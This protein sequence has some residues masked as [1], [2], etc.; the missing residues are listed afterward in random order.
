MIVKIGILQ[1][2]PFSMTKCQL[3]KHIDKK[4]KKK[5]ANI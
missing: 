1:E 3:E 5:R 4:K 2:T